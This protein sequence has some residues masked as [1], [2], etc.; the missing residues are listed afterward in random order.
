L[1]DLDAVEAVAARLMGRHGLAVLEEAIDAHRKG[2]AGTK[3]E[4]E[5]AFHALL[6]GNMAKPIADVKVLGHEVD[7]YWPE[8]KLIAEIDGPGHARP[9]ARR[10]DALRDRELHGAGYIV[11]RFTDVD[12]EQRPDEVLIMLLAARR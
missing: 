11:V 2:S 1:L 4:K 6:R 5:D 9:R 10:R 12:V 8:S 7:A 3:S